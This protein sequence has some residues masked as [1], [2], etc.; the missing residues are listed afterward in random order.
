MAAFRAN[1]LQVLLAT[2]LIRSGAW[3]CPTPTVMLIENAEQFGLAQLQPIAR[4]HR[5]GRA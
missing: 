4:A 2:P 3:T 5:T 1:A